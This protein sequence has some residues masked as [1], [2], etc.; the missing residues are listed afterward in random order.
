[1]PPMN[2][3]RSRPGHRAVWSIAPRMFDA[4]VETLRAHAHEASPLGIAL[5][6]ENRDL[7]RPAMREEIASAG[8]HLLGRDAAGRDVWCLH[9]DGSVPDAPPGVRPLA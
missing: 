8:L 5:V 6:V 4:A 2:S 7:M 1:M 9:F 3:P